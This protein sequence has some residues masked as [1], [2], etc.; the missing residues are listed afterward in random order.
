VFRRAV[1]D[2]LL[3]VPHTQRNAV[4]QI[5]LLAFI[6]ETER[7]YCAVRAGSLN[8]IQVSLSHAKG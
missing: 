4:R 3:N 8:K 2:L 7:V 1:N 6:S 5:N